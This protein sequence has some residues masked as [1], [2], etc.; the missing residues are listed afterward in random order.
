MFYCLSVSEGSVL[1]LS[2]VIGNISVK[3]LGFMP[4]KGVFTTETLITL[5]TTLHLRR[6]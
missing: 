2:T 6:L 4:N 5:T 3:M 1:Q